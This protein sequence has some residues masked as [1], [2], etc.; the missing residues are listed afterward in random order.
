MSSGV[1]I[2]RA[3]YHD[4]PL[5]GD[6]LVNGVYVPIPVAA[7][8]D[9]VLSGYSEALGLEL[10]WNRG[11]LHFWD[12]ATG[13]YLPDLTEAKAQR[14]AEAEARQAAEERIRQLE[15]ELRRLRSEF[16]ME[17]A[18]RLL[19][20][21]DDRS[22]LVAAIHEIF[23]HPGIRFPLRDQFSDGSGPLRVI[24]PFTTM[25]T[26]N[27]RVSDANRHRIASELGDFLGMSE[28]APDS[29]K[30]IPI[31][32]NRQSWLFAYAKEPLNNL[33]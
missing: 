1:S 7:G 33:A 13:A 20:H 11:E 27:R 8:P 9:G 29:F 32:N 18:D 5:A 25:G 14:D 2:P 6:R 19:E 15:L 10:R 21:R 31:L 26:F 23:E 30:S 22:R 3:E 17:F 12:P 4:A 16:Y 24:C 28:P